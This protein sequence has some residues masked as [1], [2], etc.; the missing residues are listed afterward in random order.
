MAM[1]AYDNESRHGTLISI[2]EFKVFALR[3]PSKFGPKK[4]SNTEIWHLVLTILTP[5]RN[6]QKLGFD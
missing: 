3:A 5:F 1:R 4:R 6:L 2:C